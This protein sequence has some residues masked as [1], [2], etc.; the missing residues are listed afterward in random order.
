MPA[1]LVFGATGKQGGA[2]IRRLVEAD[3]PVEI[4]AVTR[5]AESEGA[6]K[7]A[8]ESPKI[9]L[10]QGDLNEP[11]GVFEAAKKVTST[12]IEGVFSVQVAM[13]PGASPESEEVQGKALIDVALE[14][15]VKHFVYTSVDR[16]GER[17]LQNPTSI[18]HFLSK[19]H[20][21]EYLLEKS[22]NGAK[23]EYTILRP[24]AFFDNAKPGFMGNAFNAMWKWIGDKKLQCIATE[25]IG[26][27][28]AQALLNPEDP[29]YKN[30]AISLA[31]D[32]LN[33]EE[34]ATIF[35]EKMGYEM[36]TSYWFVAQ[37]LFLASKEFSTM[38]T[39]FKETEAYKA[40]IEA[41]RK[42]HPGLQDFS[43]YLDRSPYEKN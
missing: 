12:P 1:I 35:K 10:V 14:N 5:N 18:P 30:A 34:A 9:K 32:E 37:G 38:F 26:W 13:G 24:T 33:Y 23:M 29:L 40:D 42:I 31:G 15:N 16:G 43:A 11:R 21:E 17:S 28:G 7:L 39:W 22:Q 27:F 25:D 3:A 2:T 36:P 4:L 6:K 41:L 20:I 19:H 8:A